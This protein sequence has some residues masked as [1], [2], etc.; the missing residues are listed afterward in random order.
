M[1]RQE[2]RAIVIPKLLNVDLLLAMVM[3][4]KKSMDLIRCWVVR[5]LI[6]YH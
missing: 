5:K 1:W 3:A 4:Y 2:S 6:P